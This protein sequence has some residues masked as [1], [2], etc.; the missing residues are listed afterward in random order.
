MIVADGQGAAIADGPRLLATLLNRIRP[1]PTNLSL[2]DCR[3]PVQN[4]AGHVF[5]AGG[6]LD[7]EIANPRGCATEAHD[8]PQYCSR[9][10]VS[11]IANRAMRCLK[12]SVP[13]GFSPPFAGPS[14]LSA[15]IASKGS[16]AASNW[17][18]RIQLGQLIGSAPYCWGRTDRP[19]RIIVKAPGRRLRDSAPLW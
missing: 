2:G 13:L 17:R 19:L 4:A 10:S 18:D 7:G 16:R 8:Y 15:V 5:R 1:S 9:I 6:V 11:D 14:K 3:C 12:T